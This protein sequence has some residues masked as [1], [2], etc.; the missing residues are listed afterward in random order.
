[1]QTASTNIAYADLISQQSQTLQA[2]QTSLP[3]MPPQL[4]GTLN[5]IISGL[6]SGV[7][8]AAVSTVML[9]WLYP[10]IQRAALALRKKS[11]LL[12]LHIPCRTT[13][14]RRD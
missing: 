13:K 9:P 2:A 3:A 14:K 11:L 8:Q 10:Y 5:G 6:N 12:A 1:M 4:A 7:A